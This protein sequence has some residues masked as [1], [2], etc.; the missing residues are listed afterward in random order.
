MRGREIQD[1]G[2]LLS[3][4][5][6]FLM[7]VQFMN[8]CFKENCFFLYSA[9]CHEFKCKKTF[10]TETFSTMWQSEYSFY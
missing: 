5:V 2:A 9:Y 7:D 1:E 6:Q 10:D 3:L 8:L 4:D